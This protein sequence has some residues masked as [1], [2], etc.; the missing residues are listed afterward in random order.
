MCITVALALLEC[1]FRSKGKSRKMRLTCWQSSAES[2][3]KPRGLLHLRTPAAWASLTNFSSVHEEETAYVQSANNASEVTADRVHKRLP[4]C[5]I[6]AKKQVF[7]A[8]QR[9]ET[10]SGVHRTA[11]PTFL[12]QDHGQEQG[13]GAGRERSLEE[14]PSFTQTPPRGRAHPYNRPPRAPDAFTGSS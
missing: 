7:C 10:C 5:C 6:S 14:R 13:E 12:R 9:R 11:F 8:E 4:C 1:E 2:S 3:T